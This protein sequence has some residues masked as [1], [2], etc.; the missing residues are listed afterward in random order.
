MT[1]SPS[2]TAEHLLAERASTADYL[3]TCL[4]ESG[5]STWQ[6][7]AHNLKPGID[8]LYL[9]LGIVTRDREAFRAAAC[10]DPTLH[11]VADAPLRPLSD[12]LRTATEFDEIADDLTHLNHLTLTPLLSQRIHALRA[13][14]RALQGPPAPFRPQQAHAAPAKGG[15]A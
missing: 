7:E 12:L 4:R 8:A 9:R 11:S 15:E 1:T 2:E 5:L 14:V 10:K 6:V 13:A 3:N